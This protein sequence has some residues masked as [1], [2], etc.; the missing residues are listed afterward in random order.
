MSIRLQH[1]IAGCR[2]LVELS[3]LTG[4]DRTYLLGHLVS[5]WL[6]VDLHRPDGVLHGWDEDDIEHYAEWGTQLSIAW[7]ASAPA[8]VLCDHMIAVGLL[9]RLEDDTLAVP[10]W[11]LIRGWQDDPE[12]HTEPLAD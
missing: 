6:A 8:P 1:K 3:A 12:T 11:T 5:F 9:H 4:V 7:D 2:E 10:G